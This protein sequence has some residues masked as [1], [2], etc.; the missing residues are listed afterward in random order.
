MPRLSMKEFIIATLGGE[1]RAF[2]IDEI[3][4]LFEAAGY[5][6]TRDSIRGRLN[7]LTYEKRIRRVGRGMYEGIRTLVPIS[8]IKTTAELDEWLS[9]KPDS[10]GRLLAVRAALRVLPIATGVFHLDVFSTSEHWKIIQS[11]FRAS[12]IAWVGCMQNGRDI[13]RGAEEA[14]AI[15]AGFGRDAANSALDAISSAA[16]ISGIRQ[17]VN[18]YV[19]AIISYAAYA[20]DAV[21][22]AADIWESLRT[23]IQTLEKKKMSHAD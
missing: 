7:T 19:G 13:S 23:D 22:G 9:D 21:G 2:S 15:V 8:E 1:K 11:L 5:P 16:A 18:Q 3:C 10:V 14:G 4:R 6:A 12:F 17:D 20:A